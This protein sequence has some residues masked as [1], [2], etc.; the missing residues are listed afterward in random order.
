MTFE[1]FWM[2]IS[3][4]YIKT[5]KQ[6]KQILRLTGNGD[7]QTFTTPSIDFNVVVFGE[8]SKKLLLNPFVIRKQ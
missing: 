7:I 4:F 5:R 2:P 6:S 1:C 8:L 3:C